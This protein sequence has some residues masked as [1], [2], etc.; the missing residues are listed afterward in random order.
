MRD[1]CINATHG[2][3]AN[4]ICKL[5]MVLGDLPL[6]NA[7]CVWVGNTMTP[8]DSKKLSDRALGSSFFGRRCAYCLGGNLGSSAC[9]GVLDIFM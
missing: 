6:Q 7:C 5:A 8:V 3:W 1:H 2:F 9:S 4:L